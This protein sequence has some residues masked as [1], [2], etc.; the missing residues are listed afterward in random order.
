MG[1]RKG[2]KRNG[3]REQESLGAKALR[4]SENRRRSRRSDHESFATASGTS[5]SSP[6]LRTASWQTPQPRSLL[7][8]VQDDLRPGVK[9]ALT[10]D[11][12]H[13][14]VPS[15][16]GRGRCLHPG[17]AVFAPWPDTEACQ[18]HDPRHQR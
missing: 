2:R 14:F 11:N 3:R 17:S 13:E 6:D 9:P 1:R 5:E 12:C 18:F 15:D 8:M 10:C 16:E 4:R 7:A